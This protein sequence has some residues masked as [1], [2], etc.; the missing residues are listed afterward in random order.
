MDEDE[1]DEKRTAAMTAP[2]DDGSAEEG[3]RAEAG[4]RMGG[5]V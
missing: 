4:L 2:M 5:G 1:D 3:R